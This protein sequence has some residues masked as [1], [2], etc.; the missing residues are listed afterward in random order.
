M[1]RREA[2]E[3][4][5]VDSGIWIVRISNLIVLQNFL[6]QSL[7]IYDKGI[8]QTTIEAEEEDDDEE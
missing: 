6:Y 2:E 3:S 4:H 1:K 7:L 8:A 5:K